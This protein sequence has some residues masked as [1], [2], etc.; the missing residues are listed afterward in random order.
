MPVKLKAQSAARLASLKFGRSLLMTLTF[1]EVAEILKIIDAS[2]C[3]EVVLDLGGVRLEVRRGSPAS[4]S[5]PAFQPSIAAAP[6]PAQRAA[7]PSVPTA[8]LPVA[9]SVPAGSIGVCAPTVGVFYQRP[10]PKEKPFVEVGQRVRAG[11][12]L[13]LIEVMKLYSTITAPVD[14]IVEAICVAD[15]SLV[16]FDQVLIVIRPN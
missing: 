12:P 15:G 14:G 8:G 9:A 16:E 6:I 1:K 3:E 11:D 5:P 2:K 13:C 4:A 7:A 10:S